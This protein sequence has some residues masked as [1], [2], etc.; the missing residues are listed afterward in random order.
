MI[1]RDTREVRTYDP[2]DPRLRIRRRRSRGT[3]WVWVAGLVAVAAILAVVAGVV[4]QGPVTAS[5]SIPQTTGVAPPSGPTTTP[6]AP[7]R[8]KP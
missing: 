2:D 8:A 6:P 5:R 3:V 4:R 1:S 7:E